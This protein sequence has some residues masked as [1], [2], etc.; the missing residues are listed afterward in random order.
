[1]IYYNLEYSTLNDIENQIILIIRE[2]RNVLNICKT[3]NQSGYPFVC[4]KNQSGASV[5]KSNFLSMTFSSEFLSKMSSSSATVIDSVSREKHS[6]QLLH[7]LH[8]NHSP[9]QKKSQMNHGNNNIFD[10]GGT[11]LCHSSQKTNPFFLPPAQIDKI[12]YLDHNVALYFLPAEMR[13]FHIGFLFHLRNGKDTGLCKNIIPLS[14]FQGKKKQIINDH[15]DLLFL[16]SST[17]IPFLL[18][19]HPSV[20]VPIHLFIHSSINN[21]ST[22]T[23][24]TQKPVNLGFFLP[25]RRFEYAQGEKDS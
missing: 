3:D 2:V 21:Y 12:C 18:S 16:Q 24:V 13:D 4:N 11:D 17:I 5:F 14:S 19:F 15:L 8:T 23:E 6:L 1:M 7:P 20:H 25:L 22:L 10:G 9:L